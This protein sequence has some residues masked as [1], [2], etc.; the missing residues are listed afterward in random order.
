MT[1]KNCLRNLAT[2]ITTIQAVTAVTMLS[3]FWTLP[4][5]SAQGTMT[6][7][8]NGHP[9]G[10]ATPIG[11]YIESGM[12][13]G[14]PYGAENLIINGGCLSSSPENGTSYLQV[15]KDAR[16]SFTFLSG[17]HFDLFSFDA[18]EYDLGFPGSLTL[19]VV[20]YKNMG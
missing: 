2:R 11:S 8:F 5:T 13:F 9:P 6:L 15:S 7:T 3:L 19:Q 1:T 4:E 10:Y 20:G 16:L 14:N 17:R 12:Q 18:A